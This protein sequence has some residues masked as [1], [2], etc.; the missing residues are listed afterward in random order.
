MTLTISL[1][2]AMAIASCGFEIMPGGNEG[3]AE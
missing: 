1:R 2:G 3:E